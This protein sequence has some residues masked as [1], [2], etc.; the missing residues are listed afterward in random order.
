MRTAAYEFV[1]SEVLKFSRYVF[2]LKVVKILQNLSLHNGDTSEVR[3]VGAGHGARRIVPEARLVR[4]EQGQ[5]PSV[6]TATPRLRRSQGLSIGP[7]APATCSLLS[8][9]MFWVFLQC[10]IVARGRDCGPRC[11]G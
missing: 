5:E 9:K 7:A 11:L 2:I 6:F 3:S 10:D 4:E 8:P 1:V